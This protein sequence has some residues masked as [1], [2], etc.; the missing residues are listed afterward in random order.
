MAIDSLR[1]FVRWFCARANIQFV[2]RVLLLPVELKAAKATHRK[3][4]K[5][6]CK[7]RT[8]CLPVDGGGGGGGFYLL[9]AA[10]Y[11]IYSTRLPTA[12]KTTA[13]TAETSSA[14]RRFI[15]TILILSC[16]RRRRSADLVP[17][18]ALKVHTKT[19]VSAWRR[20]SR[21]RRPR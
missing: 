5:E 1:S 18:E 14:S 10:V 12:T 20:R 7:P 15:A 21:R 6:R 2:W 17:A 8:L 3:P 11:F 4:T 9:G 13:T 19:K 16:R